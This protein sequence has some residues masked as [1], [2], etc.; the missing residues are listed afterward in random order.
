MGKGEKRLHTR[1]HWSVVV[2]RCDTNKTFPFA[3][4]G[5]FI[6][7]WI[8]GR[9]LGQGQGGQRSDK[10]THSQLPWT[11]GLR[12]TKRSSQPRLLIGPWFGREN[13]LLELGGSC[14]F[15]TFCRVKAKTM[16]HGHR[17]VLRIGRPGSTGS[18]RQPWESSLF[19]RWS[20]SFPPPPLP[21]DLPLENAGRQPNVLAVCIRVDL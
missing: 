20:N 6:H 3:L 19:N 9:I 13:F 11:L 15:S 17:S 12:Q 7:G 14:S 8:Q 21:Q 2:L 4:R 16:C 5:D 10:R 18:P 1:V